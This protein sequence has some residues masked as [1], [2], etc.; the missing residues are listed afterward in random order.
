MLRREG[1]SRVCEM[2]GQ[3]A[4]FRRPPLGQNRSWLRAGDSIRSGCDMNSDRSKLFTEMIVSPLSA[5]IPPIERERERRGALFE[6]GRY[7]TK[8]LCVSGRCVLPEFAPVR[9]KLEIDD[10]PR[11]EQCRTR[12]QTRLIPHK[13]ESSHPGWKKTTTFSRS[14]KSNLIQHVS[15]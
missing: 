5:R 11:C 12:R 13:P 3:W 10:F 15:E 8:L 1:T 9:H 2:S 14:H 4:G 7:N 6:L